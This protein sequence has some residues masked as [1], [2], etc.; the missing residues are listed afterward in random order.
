MTGTNGPHSRKENQQVMNRQQ[1]TSISRK[2]R[3]ENDLI[4]IPISG[5]AAKHSDGFRVIDLAYTRD[6]RSTHPCMSAIW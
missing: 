3:P 1:S 2:R 5:L 6:R 4:V